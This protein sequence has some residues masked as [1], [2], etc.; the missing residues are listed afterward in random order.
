MHT[1]SHSQ[2]RK[3]LTGLLLLGFFVFLVGAANLPVAHAQGASDPTPIVGKVMPGSFHKNTP[4]DGSTNAAGSPVT[5]SWGAS[6]NSPKYYFCFD[7]SN[8][9]ICESSWYWND[10]TN[11]TLNNGSNLLDPGATYYWQVMACTT[12]DPKPSGC[13]QA[14]GGEWW[15]FTIAPVTFKSMGVQDG[16]ILESAKGSGVGGTLNSTDTTFRLGDDALNRQYRVILSFDTTSLPDTV[17]IQTAVLKIDQSGLPVGTNPFS[18]LGPLYASIKKGY[19]STNASLQLAD[20]NAPN[21][22]SKVG[23]F[24]VTPVS[25]WYSATLNSTGRGNINKTGLTQFRLFFNTATN[26]NFEADYMKFVSG[27]GTNQPQLIIRYYTP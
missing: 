8:D 26:D 2:I 7:R 17:I 16:W 13:I 27:D 18:V 15:S 4:S 23:V 19:F 21:T 25:G 6:T 1:I 22:A 9:K 14:D 3:I 12:G 5:L 10:D 24:G 20:F 11:F